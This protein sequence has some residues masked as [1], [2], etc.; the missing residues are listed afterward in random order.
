MREGGRKTQSSSVHEEDLIFS[1][2]EERDEFG[3]EEEAKTFTYYTYKELIKRKN[4][5]MTMQQR[6]IENLDEDSDDTDDEYPGDE[7]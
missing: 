4:F 1:S 5:V 7:K 2:E 6:N 3:E